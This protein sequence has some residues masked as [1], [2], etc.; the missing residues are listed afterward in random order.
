LALSAGWYLVLMAL[1]LAA[2]IAG[3][4]AFAETGA[5]ADLAGR[6]GSHAALVSA[7]ALVGSDDAGPA[8]DATKAEHGS[9][10]SAGR[11]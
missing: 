6:R 10:R 9:V 11:V 2:G 7:A 1:L 8:I 5:R 3:V 4:V